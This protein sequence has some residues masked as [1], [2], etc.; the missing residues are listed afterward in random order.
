[1]PRR[2][3]SFL[4]VPEGHSRSLKFRLSFFT[5]RL[6]VGVLGFF[7][8]FVIVLSFFHGKLLYEVIAGKSL[9]QENEKLKRYNA[10][11][12]DLEKE[13]REYKRFV[14]R[15]AQLAG[16]EYQGRNELQLASYSEGVDQQAMEGIPAFAEKEAEASFTL[17]SIMVQPD[18]ARGIPVGAP[19]E[20]WITQ[21]FSMNI[22]GFGAQHPGV[23]FAAKTGT[24]VKA[25]A[26]GKVILVGWDDI[27]GKLVAIDHEHGYATYYG[28]NSKILVNLGDAIRRGQVIALSGNTG[29]SSAPHLHYEI[30]KDDIPIDP[31]SFLNRR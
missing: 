18:S 24:E 22:P 5:L 19:I 13:L 6:L 23:D 16:V 7:L 10:K 2:S 26:D 8:L 3:V 15:V 12:V 31:G 4:I 1:M 28:H 17:D 29:R 27:Y 14:Q 11:V 25:T 9:K 30:R 20:G 21:G